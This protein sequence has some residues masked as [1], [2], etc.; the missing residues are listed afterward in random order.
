M[1][2]LDQRTMST[3]C[4]LISNMSGIACASDSDHTIYQLSSKIPLAIA[5]NSYS[6]IPWDTIVN[7]YKRLGEPEEKENFEDYAK[8]FE[9]F[10]ST[11]PVS[12]DYSDLSM[13]DSNIII[14]GY[15]KEDLFPQIYDT[16]ISLANGKFM[17]DSERTQ[18][19]KVSHKEY[20][21][22]NL[23]GNFDDVYTLM[24]GAT[25]DVNDMLLENYV[26]TFNI[27][28]ERVLNRFKGTEFESYVTKKF[29]PYDAKEEFMVK[30][31]EATEKTYDSVLEG[32]ETF[33]V[34]DMV[35]AAETIVNA[36][37][38][39]GHLSSGCKKPLNATREIAV[40]TRAEGLTWIKHSL[41]AI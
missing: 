40:I 2:T 29:E 41:Y 8:D 31:Y 25:P 24:W 9:S 34:E 4:I 6:P 27:Y 30:I 10:I 28:K 16:C 3:T 20:A 35:M 7:S 19:S 15:G 21:H 23:L 37:V 13:D 32:I 36:E 1:S 39:L 38:R 22:I 12:E 33:S 17:F 14:M 11:L 5:V 26:K 18:F